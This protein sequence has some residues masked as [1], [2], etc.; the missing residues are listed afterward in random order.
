MLATKPLS[1]YYQ[2]KVWPNI[3]HRMCREDG[4]TEHWSPGAGPL[5]MTLQAGDIFLE[6]PSYSDLLILG[7]LELGLVRDIVKSSP[8]PALICVH[9]LLSSKVAAGNSWS[10]QVLWFPLYPKPKPKASPRCLLGSMYF[11]TLWIKHFYMFKEIK[12]LHSAE[13][14]TNKAQG[15]VSM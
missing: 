4:Q 13:S 14:N 15:T 12:L 10:V 11:L 5:C 6:A 7:Q 2:I 3:T 8:K 9:L 1:F